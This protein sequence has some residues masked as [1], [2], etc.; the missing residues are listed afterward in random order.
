MKKKDIVD[1]I[2]KNLEVL[3]YEELYYIEDNAKVGNE[4]IIDQIGVKPVKYF[5]TIEIRSIIIQIIF[6]F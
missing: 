4:Y 5:Y 3:K 1:A 6:L 2:N